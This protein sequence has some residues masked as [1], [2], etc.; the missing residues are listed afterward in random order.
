[1]R[2]PLVMLGVIF[3][4]VGVVLTFVTFGIGIICA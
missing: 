1:M 3:I 4:V 2:E